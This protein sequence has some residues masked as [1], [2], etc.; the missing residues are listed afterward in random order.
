MA[1]SL[2]IVAR[3]AGTANAFVP[4]INALAE[5]NIVVFAY[6]HAHVVFEEHGINSTLISQFC[7]AEKNLPHGNDYILLTGTSEEV[8]DDAKWWNWAKQLNIKSIG[9]IDQWLNY[10]QRFTSNHA[11]NNKF[12]QTPDIV[13]VIDEIAK[14][15]LLELGL[16][17][18]KI[19]ITGTP[20]IDLLFAN[21]AKS[22]HELRQKLCK[23]SK[24]KLILFACDYIIYDDKYV[25]TPPLDLSLNMCIE[26]AKKYASTQSPISILIKPHPR[27]IDEEVF[28]KLEVEGSDLSVQVLNSDRLAMLHAVDIVISA[29]SMMLYE[30]TI[31]NKPAIST[32]PNKTDVWDMPDKNENIDV[33]INQDDINIILKKHLDSLTINVTKPVQKKYVVNQFISQLDL[34]K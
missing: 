15:A 9:F 2:I 26:A 19:I 17:E 5:Q 20:A 23:N 6:S 4:I 27:Q 8:N 34:A 29:T 30:A 33:C 10:W 32:Q 25:S 3:Q 16:R 21:G 31:L 12:D 13:A 22:G 7:D 18:D 14:N 1:P 28:K 24:H 11:G